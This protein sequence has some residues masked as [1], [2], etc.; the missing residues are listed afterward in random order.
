LQK[1]Q[2]HEHLATSRVADT[3]DVKGQTNRPRRAEE[4]AFQFRT[5]LVIA[6]VA[7]PHE[8][9]PLCLLRRRMKEP[10]IGGLV[11]NMDMIA[12]TPTAVDLRECCAKG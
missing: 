1:P 11:P 6:P 2:V 9:F 12:P 5:P 7:D 4:E 10:G 8:A 3:I